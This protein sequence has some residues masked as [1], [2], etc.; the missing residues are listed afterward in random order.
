MKSLKRL[1]EQLKK[2][3]IN[4]KFSWDEEKL[5]KLRERWDF[6][7]QLKVLGIE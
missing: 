5:I 6:Q 3:N 2:N 7:E 4:Q 1:V